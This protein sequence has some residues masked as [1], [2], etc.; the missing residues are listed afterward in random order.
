[1]ELRAG[2]DDNDDNDNDDE[3]LEDE[4]EVEQ[5]GCESELKKFSHF[6][7]HLTQDYLGIFKFFLRKKV[8]H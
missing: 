4:N 7:F 2:L 3:N 8:S 6:F 1:M 5:N